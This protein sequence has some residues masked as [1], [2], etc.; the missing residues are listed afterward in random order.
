MKIQRYDLRN[1]EGIVEDEHG[2]FLKFSDF[3]IYQNRQIDH[4]L[5]NE[6]LKNDLDRIGKDRDFWKNK[7]E[8][9]LAIMQKMK[10]E[11]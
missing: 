7:A 4:K 11:V 6:V 10:E 1:Q 5:H 2:Q 3:Y 9:L 8:T